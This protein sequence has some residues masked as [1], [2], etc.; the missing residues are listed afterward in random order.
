MSRDNAFLNLLGTTLSRLG[1]STT[2]ATTYF[3][4]GAGVMRPAALVTV[5][6][7]LAYGGRRV[8][9]G[10]RSLG[11]ERIYR[12]IKTIQGRAG[13]GRPE[14]SV[15]NCFGRQIVRVPSRVCVTK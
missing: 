14:Q 3:D 15:R 4:M 12:T 8:D 9:K 10:E 7:F 1:H 2:A 13:M 5:V 11:T 6:T